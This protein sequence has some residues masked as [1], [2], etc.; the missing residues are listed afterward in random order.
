MRSNLDLQQFAY[1]ASHDLQEPLR[2]VASYMDLLRKRYQGKLDADAD[3]YIRFAVDG[4][5]RMQELVD[6]L[7]AYAKAGTQA[8]KRE[9][10]ETD[11][12]LSEVLNS[13]QEKVRET[14]AVIQHDPLPQVWADRL[15]LSLVF[16]NLISNAIKFTP[17]GQ[18]PF[19]QIGC[20]DGFLE[21]H[22]FVRDCGIGFEPEYADRIFLLFQRLHSG[23]QYPGTGIGLALSKRIIEGHGGRIWAESR[24]GEGATFHFTLPALAV[25]GKTA[26]NG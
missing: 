5:K 4:A 14:A 23:N 8:L 13:L 26:G 11:N 3:V 16:Q 22:F 10:V 15:K 19:V 12:L 1:A 20:T 6:D 17:D 9:V 18:A 7:L 2:V 25:R 21:H 24:A